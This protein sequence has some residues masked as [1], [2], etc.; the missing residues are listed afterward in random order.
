[1][2]SELIALDIENDVFRK[3]SFVNVTN[4]LKDQGWEYRENSLV[5]LRNSH[6]TENA[7]PEFGIIQKIIV[8]GDNVFFYANNFP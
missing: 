7:L 1:L 5:V 4:W 6:Q 2:F 8:E 3:Y